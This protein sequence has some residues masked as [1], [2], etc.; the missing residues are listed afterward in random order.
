MVLVRDVPWVDT[1]VEV[2]CF[3]FAAL[4]IELLAAGVADHFR[5]A[6][7]RKTLQREARWYHPYQ[8]EHCVLDPC[9]RSDSAQ[10]SE[11]CNSHTTSH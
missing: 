6:M 9:F 1:C 5:S 4:T 10:W 11:R 2:P 7:G 8:G 3:R